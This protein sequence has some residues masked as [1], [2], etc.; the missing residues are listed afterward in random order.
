MIKTQAKT[1]SP[2]ATI[3]PVASAP[4]AAVSP[5]KRYDETFRENAVEHWIKTG[6]PGTQ[7]AAE[8]GISYPT[9]KEWK[10]RYHGDAMPEHDHLELE[11]RT[12]RAELARVREQRDILKKRW[13][14]SPNRPSPLP[15]HRTHERGT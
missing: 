12:L 14:F 15:N 13:A 8:L 1:P 3:T 2:A 6:Q 10:R 11:N 9:L 4:T 5:I 7:I